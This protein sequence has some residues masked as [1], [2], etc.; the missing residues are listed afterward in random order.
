[1]KLQISLPSKHCF[2]C[3]YFIKTFATEIFTN[4]VVFTFH[5]DHKCTYNENKDRLNKCEE[6]NEV[7]H[8]KL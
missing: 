6:K 3:N 7:D 1:M 5:I 8:V 4:C 2:S